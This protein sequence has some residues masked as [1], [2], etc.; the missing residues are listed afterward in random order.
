MRSP[1]ICR[2]LLVFALVVLAAPFG[3]AGEPL[4]ARID[5]LIAKRTKD[6]DKIA[7]P[8]AADAEF[9]RRI[10][11]D[12]TGSIPR[13]GEVR[14]F[15]ADKASNKREKL[16]DR[17]LASPDYARHMQEYWDVVLMDR[18]PDVRVPRPAWEE[19]LRGSFAA[20]KPFDQM[21]RE[22]L[23]NDGS[24][25]KTRPAAKFLLD[26]ELD[27]TVVTRD[28]GRLFL[29]MSLRCTQC[30]DHPLIDGFKQEHYYGIQAFFTRAF[31][32]PDNRA[33]TAV[34]A[35]KA[36]GDTNFTSVFDKSKTQKTTAP[37][38]PGLKPILD[39]K[40]DKGKEYKVAPKKGVK[41][42]P[43]YS[44]FGHL[45]AAITARDNER[46]RRAA[47]NRFWSMMLGRGLI[48]PLDADH[49]DNP[50]SH[51]ELLKLLGDEFAA[52]KFDVKWLLREIALSK[53]YQRSSEVQ[54][55]AES[56]S[57]SKFAVAI[58]KPLTPE[59]LAYAMMQ[60]TGYTDAER[61][62]LGKK[63]SDATLHARLAG[64]IAPFRS[65]FGTQPGEPEDGFVATLDQTLFLKH[66]GVIRNLI[67][68]R[69]GSLLDRAEKLKDPA[70]VAD[71]LF[72][73]VLARPPSAD[74]RQDI[75]E[76]IRSPAN[77]RSELSEVIWAMLASSEFRFNH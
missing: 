62:A 20:N 11:L 69:P 7:A 49:P 24:D 57:P 48:H 38:M 55:S 39:A 37:K 68:A 60:A 72:L 74:E 66:G 64:N 26:R 61:Q 47:A 17:L 44:R 70:A 5:A 14:A 4:H 51:P 19:Y 32:F 30:H 16:I 22:M 42:V 18:R 15:L 28:I 53:T 65:M 21:V 50:P 58:L 13:V 77:R 35:E 73:T 33:T 12:L 67:A 27:P 40:F 41:P 71:E 1:R 59:Q 10:S 31:L 52:H 43:N 6:Y 63:L 76:A 34:I 8:L 36:E 45:G 56:V 2:A 46:F 29:G 54:P 75:A 3:V 9:L 23:S 25:A